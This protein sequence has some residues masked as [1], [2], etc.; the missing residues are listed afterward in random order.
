MGVS[1]GLSGY[2][3]NKLWVLEKRVLKQ[4]FKLKEEE[5]R[6]WRKMYNKELYDMYS[7]PNVF[8]SIK[9]N[10]LGWDRFE[11]NMEENKN[12]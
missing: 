1:R 8:W 6:R 3:K 12:S 2:G 10:L 9:S 5:I 7:S 11:A 4:T